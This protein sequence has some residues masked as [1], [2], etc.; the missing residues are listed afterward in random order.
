MKTGIA[1]PHPQQVL[2][3]FQ[4]LTVNSPWLETLRPDGPAFSRCRIYS[5]GVVIRLMILQRLLPRFTLSRTVQQLVH[6]RD[7]AGTEGGKRISLRP[8]AYCRARQK[9]PTLVAVQ[10]F[11]QIADR[12]RGWL[13]PNPV[14]PDRAV[15]VLDGTTLLLPHAPDL[16]KAYPP[17]R[18]QHA[19]SHWPLMR[20]VVLQDVQTGLALRPHWGPETTS[21]QALALEAIVHLPPEAVVIGDRNFGVFG[22]AWAACR[23]GHAVLLRLTRKRAEHLAGEPLEPSSIQDITWK[24]TRWDRCGRPYPREAAVQG[25]LLCLP[26]SDPAQPEALYFF[27]TLALR[28]D[29]IRDLYALRWNVETDLRSIKQTVHLQELSAR[30]LATLEKELFLALAAYNLVRAVIC[31]ASEQAQVPPRRFSFTGVYTLVETFS[32]DL[33]AASNPRDWDTCW[34]RIITL[35]TQYLLPNRSKRRSYP[36]AVWP[37]P[38]TFPAKHSSP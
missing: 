17:H 32:A 38:K 36:R 10:V 35:A 16:T 37:K 31:L 6:S 15:F 30:S 18:N 23:Q 19:R 29:A 25:R 1:S 28:A 13:P 11:E 9:L 5:L 2:E 34:Q 27:T 14:L 21:E 20:L 26:A 12:L 7:L 22:V 8:G 4:R 24:P 3:L 33:Q